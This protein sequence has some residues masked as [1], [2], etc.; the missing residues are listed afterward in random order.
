MIKLTD[1]QLVILAAACQRA[2]R[3]ILPLP[4]SLKGGAVTK[5]IDSLTAK[6]MIEEV[7]ANRGSRSGANWRRT[8]RHSDRDRRRA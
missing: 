8:Q 3:V 5:V 2:D 6:G 1:T 7:D 4:E